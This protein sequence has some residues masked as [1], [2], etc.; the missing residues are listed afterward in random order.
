MGNKSGDIGPGRDDLKLSSPPKALNLKIL[1]LH[2]KC[3]WEKKIVLQKEN[4]EACLFLPGFWVRGVRGEVSCDCVA[5]VSLS[6][7]FV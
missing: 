6:S 2:S 3:R 1:Y 7:G 5:T 4:K